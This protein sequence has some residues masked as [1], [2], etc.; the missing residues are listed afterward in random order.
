MSR[1]SRL[2]I[3]RFTHIIVV[4]GGLVRDIVVAHLMQDNVHLPI[5]RG[6]AMQD[7]RGVSNGLHNEPY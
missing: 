1:T 7:P 5:L 6:T 2:L 4:G 3:V